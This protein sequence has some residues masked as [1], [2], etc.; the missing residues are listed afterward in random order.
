VQAAKRL[1]EHG[2]N[3]LSPPPERPEWLKYL[4]QYTNPLLFLLII[5]AALTFVAY[6]IQQPKD[7]ANIILGVVLVGV[8][9]VLAS[10][11]Y[12]NERA[13]GSVAAQL[14][15]LLPSEALVVRDGSEARV[16]A[17]D[18]VVG[19]VLH[20]TIGTRVPA[21][22]KVIVSRDFKLD[23]SSLTGAPPW[24]PARVPAGAAVWVSAARA[25]A[26]CCRCNLGRT[27][28]L[29]WPTQVTL[30]ETLAV[31]VRRVLCRRVRPSR[32]D[33]VIGRRQGA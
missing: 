26:L 13:A 18:L 14:R 7:S 16:H 10:A 24:P 9:F 28:M 11:Q 12:L 25:C 23:F 6:G 1:A 27:C 3:K 4:L 5:A 22:A 21:D 29:V 8:V 2:H 17:A 30:Q 15:N 32:D 20:M 19:D 33:N 31:D